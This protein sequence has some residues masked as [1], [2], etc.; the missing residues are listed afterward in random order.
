MIEFL[1]L[2]IAVILILALVFGRKWLLNRMDLNYNYR[3]QLIYDRAC[4]IIF[5]KAV[6]TDMS[7]EDTRILLNAAME[8]Y[9]ESLRGKHAAVLRAQPFRI[10]NQ[11]N[12][13]GKS[14]SIPQT[15]S[16]KEDEAEVIE[17]DG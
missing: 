17:N 16:Q 15:E 9:N 5:R 14:F 7:R 13:M 1:P 3:Q 11:S 8:V 6:E 4:Q 2:I 12:E 10:M